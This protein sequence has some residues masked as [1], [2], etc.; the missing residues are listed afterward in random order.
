MDPFLTMEPAASVKEPLF[1]TSALS[2]EMPQPSRVTPVRV[3]PAPEL[4]V[5]MAPTAEPAFLITAFLPDSFLSSIVLPSIAKPPPASVVPLTV[6]TA[7]APAGT[8]ARASPR[9]VYVVPS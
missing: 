7:S 5:N 6:M 8:A 9:S 1:S 4:T 3:S 2:A